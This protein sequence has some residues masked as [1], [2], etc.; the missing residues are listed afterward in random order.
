M[1]SFNLQ[2]NWDFDSFSKGKFFYPKIE[3]TY[4][5][6]FSLKDLTHAF[7]E[8]DPKENIT[9]S[10]LEANNCESIF[11]KD[12][13]F[14][15]VYIRNI[16]ECNLYINAS[17]SVDTF[18]RD[19]IHKTSPIDSLC[20]YDYL[21]KSKENIILTFCSSQDGSKYFSKAIFPF[22]FFYKFDNIKT[23][24]PSGVYPVCCY[25][26]YGQEYI[27]TKTYT[28]ICC[29]N[30][31][32]TCSLDD[33]KYQ[34]LDYYYCWQFSGECSL[35][36]Y[37]K[38]KEEIIN[39]G[40]E[41]YTG[42]LGYSYV[43]TGMYLVCEDF[44]LDLNPIC[45]LNLNCYYLYQDNFYGYDS[46]GFETLIKDTFE[47]SG[48]ILS[49]RHYIKTVN[50][51]CQFTLQYQSPQCDVTYYPT[52]LYEDLDSNFLQQNNISG[53]ENFI[54][55]YGFSGQ[56]DSGANLV[57][58][59]KNDSLDLLKTVSSSSSNGYIDYCFDIYPNAYLENINTFFCF[60]NNSGYRQ[61]NF[62]G[63]KINNDCCINILYKILNVNDL[64]YRYSFENSDFLNSNCVSIHDSYGNF[65]CK[66]TNLNEFCYSKECGSDSDA[67]IKFKLPTGGSTSDISTK[68][69]SRGSFVLPLSCDFDVEYCFELFNLN[70]GFE[71]CISGWWSH[72]CE[73]QTP[74]KKLNFLTIKLTGDNSFVHNCPTFHSLELNLNSCE[75]VLNSQLSSGNSEQYSITK[76]DTFCYF[77]FCGVEYRYRPIDYITYNGCNINFPDCC[78]NINYSLS[79]KNLN[80]DFPIRALGTGQIYIHSDITFLNQYKNFNLDLDYKSLNISIFCNCATGFRIPQIKNE[81]FNCYE[82]PCLSL[83][84]SSERIVCEDFLVSASLGSRFIERDNDLYNFYIYIYSYLNMNTGCLGS[85]SGSSY[86]SD[87][88]LFNFLKL[89]KNLNSLLYS[90]D[91]C[92]PDDFCT[93]ASGKISG[94]YD[95][96]LFYY[97]KSN[98]DNYSYASLILNCIDYVHTNNGISGGAHISGLLNNLH[99][100]YNQYSNQCCCIISYSGNNKSDLCCFTG[101]ICD[102]GYVQIGNCY[103]LIKLSDQ[104]LTGLSGEIFLN[105][106]NFITGTQPIFITSNNPIEC[107]RGNLLYKNYVDYNLLCF[108]YGTGLFESNFYYIYDI[109][110]NS[111]ADLFFKVNCELYIDNVIFCYLYSQIICSS[112]QTNETGIMYK[113]TLSLNYPFSE[114]ISNNC[115]LNN[116]YSNFN[117]NITSCL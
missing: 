84:F 79:G 17:A 46:C 26:Q 54:H 67:L 16:G 114:V 70:H 68:T 72:L 59:F 82:P 52:Y 105:N 45:N 65:L 109:T 91:I 85:L 103:H 63:I 48:F 11:V 75:Q 23:I 106:Q 34:F 69:L 102:N 71:N 28:G 5:L 47:S 99:I 44:I 31:V 49:N 13:K 20:S 58:N 60:N 9:L 87:E 50:L 6:S 2:I 53:Y 30:E 96:D 66:A 7:Y 89:E 104:K 95:C 80:F 56:V 98:S 94:V 35:T 83:E 10:F 97:K 12:F 62:T 19:L 74:Q 76:L 25:A 73:F 78:I 21:L 8:I 108:R 41:Y 3:S 88:Y 81:I 43:E 4:D 38:T 29:Y 100:S 37:K 1:S 117:I 115:I 42:L 24:N 107:I 90:S 51:T 64:Y 92:I 111:E 22:G 61:P 113:N 15:F 112:D 14:P 33:Y 36:L 32:T 110:G 55:S 57:V 18:T 40:V 101:L 86:N 116:C 93:F 39:C 77:C 27:A